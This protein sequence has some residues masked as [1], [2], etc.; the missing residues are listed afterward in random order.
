MRSC[1]LPN[2]GQCHIRRKPAAVD[3]GR[4]TLANPTVTGRKR[5][6]SLYEDDW[7][8]SSFDLNMWKV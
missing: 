3:S 7:S 1:E 5:N 8:I 6:Q 4:Q 2:I